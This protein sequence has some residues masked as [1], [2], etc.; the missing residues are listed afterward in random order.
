MNRKTL[1]TLA[2]PTIAALTIGAC[3]SPRYDTVSSPSYH[4]TCTDQFG[5]VLADWACDRHSTGARWSYEPYSTY[6]RNLRTPGYY[7]VGRQCTCGTTTQPRG[8]NGKP[9]G[10][11]YADKKTVTVFKNGKQVGSPVKLNQD[12]NRI[13]QTSKQVSSETRRDSARKP[14]WGSYQPK[15]TTNRSPFG[16]STRRR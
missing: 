12:A 9:V 16:S 13:S 6:Q 3:G 4:A 5:R 14:S 8:A 10:V 7:S 15:K 11:Q 1:I 2:L